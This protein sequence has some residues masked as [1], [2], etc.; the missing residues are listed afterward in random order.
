MSPLSLH[1]QLA[2]Y[3]ENRLN[4]IHTSK[5]CKVT[6]VDYKKCLV[7]VKPLIRDG[8][9]ED[10]LQELSEVPEVPIMVHGSPSARITFPI[11]AGDVGVIHFSDQE[12][13]SFI[14]GD[15]SVTD[16]EEYSALGLYPLYF[17]SGVNPISVAKAISKE[18]IVIENGS[19]IIEIEPSGK[20]IVKCTDYNVSASGSATIDSPNTTFTGNVSVLGS[21]TSTSVSTPSLTATSG[22]ISGVN[23]GS[24]THPYTDDG[25]VRTTGPAK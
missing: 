1:D 14:N 3:L 21:T 15:G 19:T 5:P 7:W 18:N 25:N 6:K 17:E 22:I 11:K 23:M 4:E 24:H 12:T 20:V 8:R 10:K 13:S 2:L 9:S 16:P